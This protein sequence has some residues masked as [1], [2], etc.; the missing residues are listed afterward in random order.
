M[1]SDFDDF[2]YL[3]YSCIAFTGPGE[4]SSNKSGPADVDLV[5]T[6]NHPSHYADVLHL[7]AED[8][9]VIHF[10]RGDVGGLPKNLVALNKFWNSSQL[11][12]LTAF[13]RIKILYSAVISGVF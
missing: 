8:F 10:V 5:P 2:T 7:V 9:P 12:M 3:S 4:G 13:K 6:I 1:K 11:R